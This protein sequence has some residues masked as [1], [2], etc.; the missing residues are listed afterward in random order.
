MATNHAVLLGYSEW[1]GSTGSSFLSRLSYQSAS[2]RASFPSH[3]HGFPSIVQQE[4]E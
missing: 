2:G 3:E 4:S 1:S